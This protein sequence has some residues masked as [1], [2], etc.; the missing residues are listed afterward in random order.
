M[1][2]SSFSLSGRAGIVP[3][4]F[5]IIA[6]TLFAEQRN[7]HWSEPQNITT[8]NTKPMILL[9]HGNNTIGLL[10]FNSTISGYSCFIHLQ[11]A[12]K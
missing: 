1:C 4:V 9:L 10:Y 7:E 3:F 5:I 11:Y 8:L 12:Q 2:Q 6:G